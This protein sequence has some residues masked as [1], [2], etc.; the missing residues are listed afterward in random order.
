MRDKISIVIFISACIA[1]FFYLREGEKNESASYLLSYETTWRGD[2]INKV[3]L[4]GL[5]QGLWYI[6]KQNGPDEQLDNRWLDSVG[7][8]KDG[9][10]EGYWTKAGL[11][12]QDSIHYIGCKVQLDPNKTYTF[13][14]ERNIIFADTNIKTAPPFNSL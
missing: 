8:F 3:D 1:A 11:E 10:K 9:K 4:K 2:T 6:Y 14:V 13:A 12:E 7:T 5:K